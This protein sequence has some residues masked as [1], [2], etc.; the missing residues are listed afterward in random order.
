MALTELLDLIDFG[1][2]RIDHVKAQLEH[3]AVTRCNR[4]ADNNV[5]GTNRPCGE[6]NSKNSLRILAQ[7]IKKLFQ[8]VDRNFARQKAVVETIAV[9]DLS[10]ARRHNHSETTLQKSPDGVFAA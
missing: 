2:R 4:K 7:D 10:E 1:E 6:I 8:I 5:A 9:E 3:A